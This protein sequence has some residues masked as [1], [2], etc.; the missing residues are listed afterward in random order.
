MKVGILTYHR[1][2]NYGATLQTY[3]LWKKIRQYGHDV[4]VIDYLLPQL[5]KF[6]FNHLYKNKYFAFNILKEKI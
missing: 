6:Y 4:E 3:A 1:T 5:Q 2:T